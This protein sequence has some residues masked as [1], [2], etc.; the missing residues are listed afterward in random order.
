MDKSTVVEILGQEYRVKGDSDVD[1]IESVGRFVDQK[2]RQLTKGT[3]LGSS[4]KV[5][6]LAALNIADELYAEREKVSR[7]L[8]HVDERVRALTAQLEDALGE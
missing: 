5:A 4:S 7:T 1:R 2:M 8:A 3:S 6:I